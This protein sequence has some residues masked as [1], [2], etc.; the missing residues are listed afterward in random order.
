[1][2]V[3]IYFARIHSSFFIKAPSMSV[4]SI[5]VISIYPVRVAAKVKRGSSCLNIRS[6]KS[7]DNLCYSSLLNAL[8]GSNYTHPISC[9]R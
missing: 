7:F 4:I 3:F 8:K 9:P 1:M 5:D 2:S 6:H